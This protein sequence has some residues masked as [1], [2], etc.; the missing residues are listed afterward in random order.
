MMAAALGSVPR[1]RETYHEAGGRNERSNNSRSPRLVRRLARFGEGL[2]NA[3]F[4]ISD[5][6][7]RTLR[8][9]SGKVAFLRWGKVAGSNRRGDHALYSRVFINAPRSCR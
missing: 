2:V 1:S 9:E 5:V 3:L 6:H 7:A 4:R 8:D